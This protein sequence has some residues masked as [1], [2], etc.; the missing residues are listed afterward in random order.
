MTAIFGNKLEDRQLGVRVF[1]N[2]PKETRCFLRDS[3]EAGLQSRSAV[4]EK[5]N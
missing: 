3:I 4:Q 5:E 1:F 2:I